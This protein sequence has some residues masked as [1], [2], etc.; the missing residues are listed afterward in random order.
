[1]WIAAALAPAL[2]A[3]QDWLGPRDAALRKLGVSYER[4]SVQQDAEN[5]EEGSWR[6]EAPDRYVRAWKVSHRKVGEQAWSSPAEM[7]ELR[8]GSLLLVQTSATSGHPVVEI[9]PA[10]SE[11]GPQALIDPSFRPGPC[12]PLAAGFPRLAWTQ[13]APG[14]WEGTDRSVRWAVR[15][16]PDGVPESARAEGAAAVA[17]FLYEGRLK[18]GSVLLPRV[19]E[20]KTEGG[21]VR[22]EFRLELTAGTDRP[23]PIRLEEV[24]WDAPG[25]EVLDSR[26]QPAALYFEGEIPRLKAGRNGRLTLDDLLEESRARSS[27]VARQNEAARRADERQRARK[28]R[29]RAA[30]IAVAAG[31]LGLGMFVIGFVA[32]RRLRVRR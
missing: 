11:V 25:V 10:P 15:V 9:R 29:E 18:A 22:V 31:A 32:F 8:L 17:T 27:K 24:P 7:K 28:A 21:E 14:T 3:A 4:T 12:L 20:H 16:A 30:S 2:C 1:M 5:R 19:C 23:E 6:W 13:T 26:V